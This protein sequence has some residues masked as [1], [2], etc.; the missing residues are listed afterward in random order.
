MNMKK[1][2][3]A[4][5]LVFALAMMM[6]A[7]GQTPASTDAKG[8]APAS[9]A[10]GKGESDFAYIKDKGEMIIGITLFAPMNYEEKGELTGFETEFAKAVCAKL[11]VTPKFQEIDWNSKEIELNAK[12]IDCIW[13]GMTVT[14]ERKQNM[15]L[16]D[17]Y[18]NNKQVIVAKKENVEKFSKSVDGANIVAENGSTGE[19]LIGE[20]EFFASAKYTAVD[21]QAKGLTDVLAGTADAVVVDYVLSIGS[22]GEGTDFADLALVNKEFKR[23]EYAVAF[24]KGSDVTKEVNAVIKEL[25]ADGTLKKLAEKYKLGE[26]LLAK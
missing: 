6:T 4:L 22:I 12:N 5:A 20:D 1:I 13:N 21:S 16:T 18:M 15:S 19:E 14:D 8:T 3:K 24:R 9:A 11:G 7:C 26:M 25:A 17:S 10:A 23:D 2:W